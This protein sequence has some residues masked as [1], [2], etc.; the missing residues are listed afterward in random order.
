MKI[1]TARLAGLVL[2][3]ALLGVG[4]AGAGERTEPT[5]SD[6]C[7]RT[8]SLEAA[9]QA[10]ARGDRAQALEHLRNAETLLETCARSSERSTPEQEADNG[11]PAMALHSTPI[12]SPLS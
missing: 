12:S 4:T 8:A 6:S 7:G 1:H 5:A 9:K 11:E 2:M 3:V 10:L